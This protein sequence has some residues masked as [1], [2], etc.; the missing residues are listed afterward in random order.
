MAWHFTP[1]DAA[2]V[3]GIVAYLEG[4]KALVRRRDNRAAAEAEAVPKDTDTVKLDRIEAK[5]DGVRDLVIDH[6]TDHARAQIG[7]ASWRQR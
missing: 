7:S 3:A 1:D 6:I 4:R 2:V 5:L